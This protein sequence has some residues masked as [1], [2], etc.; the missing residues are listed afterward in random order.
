MK[1]MD[2]RKLHRIAGIVIAP[3]L[4]LQAFSGILLSV[5]WLLGIHQRVGEAIVQNISP[6]LGL[7]DMIL[8]NI[9][10]GP[11]VGGA[12]LHIMLGSGTV[13]VAVSGIMIFL[14]IRERQKHQINLR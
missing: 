5:D 3:L 7:W 8:V 1:E 9:H 14:K 12:F 2:L 4:I 11:E 6:L 13:G 10:Y